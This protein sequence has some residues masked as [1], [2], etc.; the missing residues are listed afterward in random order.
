MRS[1][2]IALIFVASLCQTTFAHEYWLEPEKFFLAPNEKTPVH[3]YVGDG[4]VKER[5]ERAYDAEKTTRFDIMSTLVTT[6]LRADIR[7][8]AKPIYTF[9]SDR[10]GTYM[11]AMERNWSYI[12]LPADK[13]EEYLREDGMEYIISAREKRGEKNAEG[14]ERYARFLKTIVK[15]GGRTDNVYKKR[16]GMELEIIPLDD[17]YGGAKSIRFS[18]ILNGKPLTGATVFAD[19]RDAAQQKVVTG[20]NG[21]ATFKIDKPG[22]WIVRLV[23][24]RRCAKD[25]GEADWESLWGA[26]TFGSR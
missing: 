19:N 16:V 3:L 13:F 14:R 12:K 5:E 20:V 26:L 1:I 15:V 18:V 7:Q 22:M 11:F 21:V 23:T 24:M 2:T 17:P 10:P 8:G 6:D 25:C 9:W 4:L